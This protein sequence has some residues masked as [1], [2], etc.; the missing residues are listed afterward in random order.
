MEAVLD[1]V[2]SLRHIYSDNQGDTVRIGFRGNKRSP[3][4]QN[5]I[6]CSQNFKQVVAEAPNQQHCDDPVA[7]HQK[8]LGCLS[9]G[10]A[11]IYGF[12]YNSICCKFA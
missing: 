1:W 5:Y 8:P 11:A 9:P 2:D 12:H 3:F 6:L 4:L 10:I 7:F